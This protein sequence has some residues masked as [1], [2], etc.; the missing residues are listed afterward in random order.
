MALVRGSCGIDCD[1]TYK[2]I[3]IIHLFE[4]EKSESTKKNGLVS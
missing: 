4:A 3:L 1:S 2:P